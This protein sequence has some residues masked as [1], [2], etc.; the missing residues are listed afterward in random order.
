MSNLQTFELRV[1]STDTSVLHVVPERFL[2]K[3]KCEEN[4][5]P[6]SIVHRPSF[7]PPKTHPDCH[8][9]HYPKVAREESL[10]VL[11]KDPTSLNRRKCV[12]D[13]DDDDDDDMLQE[14]HHS[15][16]VFGKW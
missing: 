11:E 6:K 1:T 2:A 3:K 10:S 7:S 4:A 12:D 14:K 16:V 5:K 9:S 13:D 8:T 15:M